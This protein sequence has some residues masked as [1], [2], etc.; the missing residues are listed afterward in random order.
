MLRRDYLNFLTAS[1]G[2]YHEEMIR[3]AQARAFSTM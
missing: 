1:L 3:G 2:E